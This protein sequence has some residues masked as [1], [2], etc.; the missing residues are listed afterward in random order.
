M[1]NLCDIT[2][3][4]I[5]KRFKNQKIKTKANP[6]TAQNTTKKRSRLKIK[7]KKKKQSFTSISFTRWLTY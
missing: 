7:H 1:F 3:M 2:Q 5:L 6:N 4:D